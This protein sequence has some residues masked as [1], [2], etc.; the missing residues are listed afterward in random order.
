MKVWTGPGNPLAMNLAKGTAKAGKEEETSHAYESRE[1]GCMIFHTPT[2]FEG[3]LALASALSFFA[4]DGI[5]LAIKA[6]WTE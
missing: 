3:A 2:T 6:R 1:E 4:I 5:S